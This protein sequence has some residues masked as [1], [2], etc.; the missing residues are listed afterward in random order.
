MKKK[1]LI[2]FIAFVITACTI[3]SSSVVSV[4]AD[5]SPMSV[6]A[7]SYL[8]TDFDMTTEIASNEKDKRLPIASMVKIM[9][10]DLIFD[11]IDEGKLSLEDEIQVS[12]NANSMGGSQ[13]YLDAGA[14]YKA[15]ELIKS[16]IVASANDSC[17]AM[18]EHLAGSVD[19]FV[20]LMNQKA[21]SLEMHDT[22]FVN[23]TGLPAPNEYS[24]AADV[25][26]MT[27]DLMTH[28]R[29]FDYSGI[30]TFDFLH[31]SGRI[32]TLTNTNKLSR[33]YNGCDGGKTG[34]TSE[35]LSCLSAT[36][37]RGDTRLLCVVIGAPSSKIRNAEVTKLFNYG[38]AN[39][40]NKKIFSFD[41]AKNTVAEVINGKHSPIKVVPECEIYRFGARN[42]HNGAIDVRF[43]PGTVEAPVAVG[44]VVGKFEVYENGEL[45]KSVNALAFE[46]CDRMSFMDII[47]DIAKRW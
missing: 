13:A 40:E 22:H 20:A 17:V 15:E 42:V 26:K 38:F 6:N 12:E 39:F 3:I 41:D 29:F 31:P 30:W 43:V 10:L 37:K 24:T 1:I 21:Q 18:A 9:T 25:L 2:A 36:A 11:S 44:D 32:T 46:G 4:K 7:K 34:Y 27:R 45:L 19:A 8:I 23:C 16:I 28:E 47:G 33:F 5:S 14:S 35:A